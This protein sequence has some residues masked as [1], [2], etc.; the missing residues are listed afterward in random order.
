MNYQKQ[1]MRS[2]FNWLFRIKLF[3]DYPNKDDLDH[4]PHSPL[5]FTKH[6]R[7]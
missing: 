3:M 7:D 5:I 2:D 4:G 6:Q 1:K